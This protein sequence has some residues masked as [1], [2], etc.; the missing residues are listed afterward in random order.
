MHSCSPRLLTSHVKI[1]SGLA[2]TGLEAVEMVCISFCNLFHCQLICFSFDN[3][4]RCLNHFYLVL[5]DPTNLRVWHSNGWTAFYSTRSRIHYITLI[6]VLRLWWPTTGFC[7]ADGYCKGLAMSWTYYRTAEVEDL[8][9]PRL[10]VI[11]RNLKWFESRQHF[12]EILTLS[13]LRSR[14]LLSFQIFKQFVYSR[15]LV[16]PSFAS[17]H[18]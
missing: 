3:C 6:T 18:G 5:L 4:T 15:V 8:Y 10:N 14:T 1:S 16:H 13:P 17:S 11:G 9:M 7:V 2:I 12:T